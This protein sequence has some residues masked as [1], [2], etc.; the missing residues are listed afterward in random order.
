MKKRAIELVPE[1]H[2][3]EPMPALVLAQHQLTKLLAEEPDSVRAISR[4]RAGSRKNFYSQDRSFPEFGEA[5][6]A[7][8]ILNDQWCNH[9]DGV[10]IGMIEAY[11]SPTVG[12]S[13]ILERH[14]AFS[15]RGYTPPAGGPSKAQIE[16]LHSNFKTCIR[17]DDCDSVCAPGAWGAGA[18]AGGPDACLCIDSECVSHHQTQTLALVG[19]YHSCS[20]AFDPDD[21]DYDVLKAGTEQILGIHNMEDCE[22]RL[23][24]AANAEFFIA[25]NRVS[26]PGTAAAINRAKERYEWLVNTKQV[27]LINESWGVVDQPD[28]GS[29]SSVLSWRGVLADYYSRKSGITIIQAAGQLDSL[30]AQGVPE[31]EFGVRCDGFNTLCVGGA[32][33]DDSSPGWDMSEF[34]HFDS[35]FRRDP[36]IENNASGTRR[37]TLSKPDVVTHARGVTVPAFRPN[38]PADG[39]DRWVYYE[40]NAGGQSLFIDAWLRQGDGTSFAAPIVTGLVA[41]LFKA[42]GVRSSALLRAEL[43]AF[44]THQPFFANLNPSVCFPGPAPAYPV[45]SAASATT[46]QCDYS[47]GVGAP[48]FFTHFRDFCGYFCPTGSPSP[49]PCNPD[50]A[51]F[52]HCPATAQDSGELNLRDD[53]DGRVMVPGAAPSSS[54][55]MR[56]VGNPFSSGGA[57]DDGF[58]IRFALSFYSCPGI[59]PEAYADN[60]G[61]TARPRQG[62]EYADPPVVDFNVGIVAWNAGGMPQLLDR[63]HSPDETNE[64]IWV[65]TTQGW[66]FYQPVIIEPQSYTGCDPMFNPQGVVGE[67]VAWALKRFDHPA[68]PVTHP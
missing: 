58:A 4:L 27:N 35:V 52:G 34:D 25:N 14:S 7:R 20:D 41:Q 43:R 57:S 40:D 22:A 51:S 68:G 30:N 46:Q 66:D 11:G 31:N 12:A 8:R 9:G 16:Y 55:R 56:Y 26:S 64:S 60:M 44:Q 5:T 13:R 49:V 15:R 23:I 6:Y 21:P 32:V 67:P 28:T 48:S 18:F 53:D 3:L 42:S 29:Y 63:T 39:K 59:D 24:G 10:R 2:D 38:Q 50:I 54:E 19:A 37:L 36:S 17:N 61:P 62:Q 65:S 47:A 33:F 1:A 45:S